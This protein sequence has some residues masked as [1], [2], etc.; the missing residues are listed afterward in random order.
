M[1]VLH[2]CRSL[3]LYLSSRIRAFTPSTTPQNNIVHKLNSKALFRKNKTK[4]NK[5]NKTKQN[6]TTTTTTTKNIT[7]NKKQN[8]TKHNVCF[9]FLKIT[10]SISF[11]AS[12]HL[13]PQQHP[14]TTWYTN[15]TPRR[16]FAKTKQNKTKNKQQRNKN[17]KQK[18]KKQTKNNQKQKQKTKN[19]KTR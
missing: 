19:K 4:Q 5:T 15:L 14:R 18:N 11:H 16:Y 13:H 9:T 10:K 7:K 1:Y 2:S 8:K 12:V 3:N 17:K 6:K